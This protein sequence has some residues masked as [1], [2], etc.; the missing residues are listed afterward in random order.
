MEL[1][2]CKM[3][4]FKELGVKRNLT[5]LE[6]AGLKE[7]FPIQ[8]EAI[9][10]LLQGKDIIGQAQTG[11]GKTA[12][13]GLPILEGIDE[14]VHDTQALIIVPTRELAAQVAQE[15]KKFSG[16]RAKV[17]AVYGG[18]SMLRQI[19]F[20]R[21]ERQIVV[22]TPGR[23]LDYIRDDVIS[24]KRVRFVV[25]DEADRMLDMGFIDDV[26]Q[27]LNSLP[28][29][30]QTMMFSATMPREII[31]LAHEFLKDPE[32][33]IVSRDEISNVDIKQYYMS[34][35]GRQKLPQLCNLLK[36]N[37]KTIVFCST[38]MRVKDI[39]EE[40]YTR[41]FEVDAIHGDME[42]PARTRVINDFK[43]HRS[44]ILIATD[45]VAR[46]IDVPF[47]DRI[48]SYDVPREKMAYFHR[49]GRTARAGE[50]GVAIMFV[51]EE[52]ENDFRDIRRETK[53]KIEEMKPTPVK[54]FP[55]VRGVDRRRFGSFRPRGGFGRK[56]P[57]REAR[58]QRGFGK[59]RRDSGGRN[60]GRR[61]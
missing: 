14:S 30:R 54:D 55:V 24:L 52:Y 42:Q 61:Y 11:T 57:G 21:S 45:V 1:P 7:P 17:T 20:L 49:I 60:Y 8:K 6:T 41:G 38:K 9:P 48:I 2:V 16:G 47:V 58:H 29:Q 35:S 23:M 32:K 12:A 39:A 34:I 5:H 59:K 18:E 44:N 43:A 4:T 50:K 28:R 19:R 31:G 10:V 3:T 13:F 46:G 37:K 36:E 40:L 26:K 22:A 27:I 53:V 33:I 56:F 51:T 15:I 25:L